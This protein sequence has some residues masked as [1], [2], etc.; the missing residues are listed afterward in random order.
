V[1]TW[2]GPGTPFPP[3]EK[4]LKNPAGLLAAGGDLS[5][6]RL[7]EAYRRGIFPWYSGDEPLLWWS[8]DPRMVLYCAELKI[9]R[10]LAKSVRNR[11]YELRLDTAFREVLQGCS[12]PRRD[13][14]G[15]WLGEDMRKAYLAL[16]R[17]GHA[18]CVETW[19]D[20]ELVGGLYGVS[21]GRMF[22]GE[23]MFSRATDA[24]KVALV[25]LVAEL[26]RR[27]FPL[28]DCQVRT[29]LLA[30]LGAREVPRRAFL[31]EIAALV[32]YDEA[33]GKWTRA[34]E[35]NVPAE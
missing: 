21:L 26:R 14:G 22:Y 11:G 1:L 17:A 12:G 34:L 7:L 16:H 10:S 25:G 5:R 33:P 20:G 27:G 15:T 19:R 3:V 2:L 28:V 23:S 8:P 32:N 4:A 30:S 31:R 18:H 29:P 35:T 9:S 24:S 13:E 6:A